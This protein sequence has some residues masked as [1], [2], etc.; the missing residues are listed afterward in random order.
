M[1]CVWLNNSYV[2]WQIS[3]VPCDDQIGRDN[4][5]NIT[6]A[7]KYIHI[8]FCCC[9]YFF[10]LNMF[11]YHSWGSWRWHVPVLLPAAVFTC[12]VNNKN[13]KMITFKRANPLQC[14]VTGY[15][16][17]KPFFSKLLC[18]QLLKGHFQIQ[19]NINRKLA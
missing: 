17:I 14:K 6:P 12:N 1:F 13:N 11:R 7:L 16:R 15:N 5:L 18:E 8:Y 4:I 9:I 3:G 19:R 10:V 2:N